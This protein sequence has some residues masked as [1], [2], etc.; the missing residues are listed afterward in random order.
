M[1]HCVAMGR[2]RLKRYSLTGPEGRRA[3]ELGLVDG[4]WFRS[5]VPRKRMKELMRRSDGPGL[6][7][8][9]VWLGALVV[10]GGLGCVFWGTW[11]TVPCFVAYGLLYGSASEGRR[12]EASH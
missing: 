5:E 4:D 8:T 1:L 12:H 2:E 11:L 7:D 6:R 10:F 9:A 3:A